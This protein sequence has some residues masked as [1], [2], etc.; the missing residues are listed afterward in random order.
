MKRQKLVLYVTIVSI[1]IVGAVVSAVPKHIHAQA[2]N[3]TEVWIVID[4][5][6]QQPC[7]LNG[8]PCPADT[9]GQVEVKRVPLAQAAHVPYIADDTS[10]AQVN[11]FSAPIAQAILTR[12]AQAYQQ[13]QAHIIRPLTSCPGHYVTNNLILSV[14]GGTMHWDWTYYIYPNGF[15]NCLESGYQLSLSP[16]TGN[17]SSDVVSGAV[18][19][20]SNP[21]QPYDIGLT[22]DGKCH[23]INDHPVVNGFSNIGV[24]PSSGPLTLVNLYNGNCNSTTVQYEN[25]PWQ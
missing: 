19:Y 15:T 2:T 3:T 6:G 5:T 17:V 11:A 23:S 22:S 4:K 7:I 20:T 25:V 18:L 13:A 16:N 10:P 21:A 9:V 24:A 14:P 1:A 12:H 8:A